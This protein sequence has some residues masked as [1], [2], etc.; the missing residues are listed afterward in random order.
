MDE[1]DNIHAV[2][3]QKVNDDSEIQI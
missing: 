2:T 1:L 3:K